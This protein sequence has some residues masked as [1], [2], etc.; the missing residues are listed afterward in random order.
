MTGTTPSWA[1]VLAP[2]YSFGSAK[3]STSQLQVSGNRASGVYQKLNL[4]TSVGQVDSEED[5]EE[6]SSEEG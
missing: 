4:G 1:G 5:V 2:L 3:A 6:V